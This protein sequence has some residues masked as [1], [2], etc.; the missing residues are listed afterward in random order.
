M[1]ALRAGQGRH[2]TVSDHLLAPSNEQTGMAA[3]IHPD[4]ALTKS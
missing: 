3:F 4:I 1:A 2:P